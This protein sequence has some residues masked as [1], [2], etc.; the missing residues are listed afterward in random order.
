MPW[1][2]AAAGLAL[3]GTVMQA[4][5]QQQQADAMR[6]QGAANQQAANYQAQSMEIQAGQERAVAQRKSIN[7]RRQEQ[8][9]ISRS[10]ALAAASGAGASDPTVISNE[11]ITTREGEFGALTD[12]YQGEQ[13]AQNL[14]TGAK[15]KR[16][17]G[18]ASD[19]G[20][21]ATANATDTAAMGTIFSGAG[22]AASLYSKYG[23]SDSGDTGLI[24][25]KGG[26]SDP[27]MA[28]GGITWN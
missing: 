6:A 8:L 15:L 7:D 20:A 3:V 9:Q 23:P 4:G 26:Y 19:Y 24:G 21:N 25:Y 5:A 28:P 22:K 16:Y 17:E 11:N 1:G 18:D 27:S 14:E 12:M 2:W 13:S 10:Q